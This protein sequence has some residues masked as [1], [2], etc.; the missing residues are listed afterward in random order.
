[1]KYS[2]AHISFRSKFRHVYVHVRYDNKRPAQLLRYA[3]NVN[4]FAEKL[5]KVCQR[6]LERQYA[7][8]LYH[9]LQASMTTQ[10]TMRMLYRFSKELYDT[11]V[12]QALSPSDE[13]SDMETTYHHDVLEDLLPLVIN[14]SIHDHRRETHNIMNRYV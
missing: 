11:I 5:S 4:T 7:W 2:Q 13:D 14:G 1:M 12:T 9:R 10:K 8:P 6:I 3:S